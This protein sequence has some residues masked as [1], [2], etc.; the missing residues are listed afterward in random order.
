MIET[1]LRRPARAG[2]YA[3]DAIRALIVLSVIVA[4]FGWGLVQVGLFLLTLLGALVPR[5]LGVRPALDVATGLVL[6]VAAWSSVLDLYTRF[7]GWDKVVHILLTGLLAALATIAA[8]RAGLLPSGREHS[9][10]LA[11]VTVAFGIAAG[12][13]WEGLEWAGHTLAV[14]PIFVSYDDN[15]RR[16]RGGRVRRPPRRPGPAV[17][18]R[19]QRQPRSAP[20]RGRSHERHGSNLG[21]VSRWVMAA[22]ARM[23][24]PGAGRQ[25]G[26][27]S[28]GGGMMWGLP[29]IMRI[30][31]PEVWMVRWWYQHSSTPVVHMSALFDR[32]GHHVVCFGVLR[33][34]PT[35][36]TATI[37][38]G[39]GAA[40]GP[41]EGAFRGSHPVD[42]P[43]REQGDPLD[44]VRTG[45]LLPP[46]RR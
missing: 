14:A 31:Q 45:Q 34:Q 12:A 5:A 16:P 9:I 36:R 21:A 23:R 13:V 37:P 29:L 8:Q 39:Q 6:L 30:C 3:A 15:D 19:A 1:F 40:L 33:C 38:D 43:G 4:G 32:P 7:L 2:E 46:Q 26:G 28:P 18:R 24:D 11:V 22:T 44:P 17:P 35:D 20:V 10:G 41:V 27:P 25:S 42:L